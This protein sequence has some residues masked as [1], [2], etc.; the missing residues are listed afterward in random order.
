MSLFALIYFSRQERFLIAEVVVQGENVIDRD[1][2]A[3]SVEDSLAGHYLWI[4]PRANA[5]I[6]PRRA[7]ERQLMTEFPRFKSADLN[8]D[9]PRTIT[10]SVEERVPFALYCVIISECFFLDEEGYIFA[11]AP[12]FSGAV[13]FIY[14]TET[15]IENPIGKNLM[16][17]DT[18]KSLPKFMEKFFLLGIHPVALAINNDNYILTLPKKGEIVWRRSA[19]MAL[20]Y[21][22]LEAFF[23]SESIRAQRDFLDKI[24]GLALRPENKIFYKFK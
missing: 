5:L 18:F 15:P 16:P 4:I 21:S 11:Q 22:N 24:S 9:G 19:D 23:S 12:S 7:I 14:T 2:I 1:K 20:V 13:Y 6:Y 8:L 17:V 10:I 3:Q